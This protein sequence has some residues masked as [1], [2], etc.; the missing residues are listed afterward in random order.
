MFPK[1]FLTL[2]LLARCLL[3]GVAIETPLASL[4]VVALCVPHALK[5]PPG[6]VVAYPHCV[7][8]HVAV[9]VAPHTGSNRPGLSQGVTIVTVF[10]HLTAHP[11]TGERWAGV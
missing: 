11:C 10:A 4:A 3:Q 1:L 7:E 6:E 5:T 8:V 9:A 2:A